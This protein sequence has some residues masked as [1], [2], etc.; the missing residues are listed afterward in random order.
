ME[1][2]LSISLDKKG[3]TTVQKNLEHCTYVCILHMC[4]YN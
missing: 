3:D 4:V 1:Y 2:A